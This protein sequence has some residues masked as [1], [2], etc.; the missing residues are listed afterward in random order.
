MWCGVLK[1]V[2]SKFH[3]FLREKTQAG[4]GLQCSYLDSFNLCLSDSEADS[5]EK[6]P[7]LL[8]W[9]DALAS[10]SL[11]AAG[12]RSS[13]CCLDFSTCQSKKD[14]PVVQLPSVMVSN[15]T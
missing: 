1:M 5:A 9:S 14:H 6:R 2:H 10:P 12:H 11:I 3:V 13:V 15:Y 7:Q 4:K 8:L